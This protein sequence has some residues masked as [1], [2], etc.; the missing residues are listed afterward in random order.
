MTNDRATVAR[1][2]AATATLALP[3]ACSD[4]TPPRANELFSEVAWASGVHFVHHSGAAGAFL[5]PEIMGGGAGFVD[6]DGDGYLDIYLVDSDGPNLL[7][8]N[9][10]DAMFVDV[11]DTAGVGE[12][13]YGMGCAVGDYDNDGDDDLYV[14]NLGANVLYRN[15]GNGTFTD[16][17][18]TAGVG[19]RSYRW[20]CGARGR[21][22]IGGR[23]GAR[24]PSVIGG[25]AAARSRAH[26]R[27]NSRIAS[28]C[29]RPPMRS[30]QAS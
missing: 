26:Q 16:V 13:G 7:Y 24:G 18:H 14:T 22:V 6:I 29:R 17:T 23:A 28:S 21:S 1:L 9:T 30:S 5:L 15:N 4:D 19:D 11:T 8:R 27:G 12:T 2:L 10:G 3:T 20:S 25:R